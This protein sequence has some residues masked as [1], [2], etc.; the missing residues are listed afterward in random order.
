MTNTAMIIYQPKPVEPLHPCIERG[1]S[2]AGTLTLGSLFGYA[3]YGITCYVSKYELFGKLV[4][5][6][7]SPV[8]FVLTPVIFLS[9]TEGASLIRDLGLHFL[10][11]R[12]DY[13]KI[14]EAA[15]LSDRLKQKTWKVISD[16]NT[17]QQNIDG[18]YSNFFHIKTEKEI[19]EKYKNEEEYLIDDPRIMEIFRKCV[20]DQ[21]DE[22]IKTTVPVSIA[23]LTVRAMGYSMFFAPW[24][25]ALVFVLGILEKVGKTLERRE[26]AWGEEMKRI[27]KSAEVRADCDLLNALFP[28]DFEIFSEKKKSVDK[29]SVDKDLDTDTESEFT[30]TSDDEVIKENF[31]NQ[32]LFIQGHTFNINHYPE[33]IPT[34]HTVFQSGKPIDNLPYRDQ[35]IEAEV[36]KEMEEALK[37]M[38][39]DCEEVFSKKTIIEELPANICI[40]SDL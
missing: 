6:P 34:R 13:E 7:T 9:V 23:L 31:F 27:N 36:I 35:E 10:G 22:T 8:P 24:L 17:L 37:P 18:I 5:V 39:F 2:I 21:F 16:L 25:D 33:W 32:V 15:G 26:Q 12:K 4:S 20:F 40:A 11:N 28:K 30:G 19:N 38:K 29:D 3:V 1:I 14:D